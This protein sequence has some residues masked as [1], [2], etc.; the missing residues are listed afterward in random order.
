M[1]TLTSS[2]AMHKCTACLT[3]GCGHN[4]NCIGAKI[5]D[6]GA[7]T[8]DWSGFLFVVGRILR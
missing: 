3:V 5:S 6:N 8:S 1:R 7:V 4:R 2:T